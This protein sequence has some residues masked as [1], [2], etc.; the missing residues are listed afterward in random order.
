MARSSRTLAHV[1]DARRRAA[2][3]QQQLRRTAA[4]DLGQFYGQVFLVPQRPFATQSQG[5]RGAANARADEIRRFHEEI[6]RRI[7][8]AGFRTAHDAGHADRRLTVCDHRHADFELA[9]D[10]VERGHRFA[11]PRTASHDTRAAQLVGIVEVERLSDFDLD[12]VGDVD[13]PI[14]AAHAGAVQAQYHPHGRA[15]R[16]EPGEVLSDQP[17]ADARILDGDL[18]RAG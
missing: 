17:P 6:A 14:D 3:L 12:V 9:H 18:D 10:T 16:D 4:T 8:D 5:D 11:R 1:D 2:V 7:A 15:A 13:E